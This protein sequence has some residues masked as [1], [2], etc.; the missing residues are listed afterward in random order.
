M[1]FQ[2]INVP[3]PNSVKN[4]TVFP[5]LEAP[6]SVSNLH[7]ALDRYKNAITDLQTSVWINN[8]DTSL[9]TLDKLS[10]KHTAF[11]EAGGNIK[12]AK[13]FCNVI[14]QY[15]FDIPLTQ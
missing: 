12:N 9:R 5:L 10:A 11:L 2:V 4:S 15:F 7:I 1:S 3:K 6:D 13:H 8:R 14:G